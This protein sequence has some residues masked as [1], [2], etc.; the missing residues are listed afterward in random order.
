MVSDAAM[1][2]FGNILNSVMGALPGFNQIVDLRPVLELFDLLNTWNN[3]LPITDFL[4]A[5]SIALAAWLALQGAAM[6]LKA[7]DIIKP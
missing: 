7:V 5:G 1:D 2:G 3:W 4:L 6:V